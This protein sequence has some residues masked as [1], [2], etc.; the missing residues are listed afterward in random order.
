MGFETVIADKKTV[1]V[2]A[3]SCPQLI[4]APTYSCITYANPVMVFYQ[5]FHQVQVIWVCQDIRIFSDLHYR[6]Q[7]LPDIRVISLSVNLI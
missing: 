7:T 2:G 6:V 3:Y 4:V 5:S 1:D